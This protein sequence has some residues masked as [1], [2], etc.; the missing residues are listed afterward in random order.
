MMGKGK[1]I[2]QGRTSEVFVWDDE[3]ILKLYRKGM[4]QEAIINEFNIS[5]CVYEKGLLTPFAKEIVD[6]E[7]RKGIVFER[8]RGVTMMQYFLSKPWHISRE[9]QRLAELH[10]EMHKIKV[11]EIPKQKPK[12]IQS[13]K[14]TEKLT[15]NK[16]QVIIDY[17]DSLIEDNSLCHGDFHPDNI[18]ISENK[19]IVIDWMTGTRGSAVADIARTYVLL[20]MGALPLGT[21]KLK[22]NIIE[23]V[24]RKFYS[25]YIKQYLKKSSILMEDIE[26]WVL[27]IAA[28]RLVEWLPEYEKVELLKIIDEKISILR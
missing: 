1:I 27:P 9:A 28:A 20:K 21:S 24:R 11:S 5:N 8:V 17:M 19:Y 16:K 13:I 7:E 3:N 15:E 25:E 2:G 14:A 18:L 23:F 26:K 6:I 12:L 22:K 4:P 10:Y